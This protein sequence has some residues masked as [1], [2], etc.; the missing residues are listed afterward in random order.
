MKDISNIC[1]Q[2]CPLPKHRIR[3][4]VMS[5]ICPQNFP[6]DGKLRIERMISDGGAIKPFLNECLKGLS[7]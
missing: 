6:G 1:V 5:V 7:S 3:G 4:K 2:F